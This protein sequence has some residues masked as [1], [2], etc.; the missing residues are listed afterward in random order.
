MYMHNFMY[1]KNSCVEKKTVI[2]YVI[3]S[4]FTTPNN[5]DNLSPH[6]KEIRNIFRDYTCQ[7]QGWVMSHIQI[8]TCI[9]YTPRKKYQKTAHTLLI[10]YITVN[11]RVSV[12]FYLRLTTLTTSILRNF[13]VKKIIK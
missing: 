8:I 1:R 2:N 13:Y 7:H 10:D 9:Y 3:L 12:V 4:H 6:Q 5:P 11:L